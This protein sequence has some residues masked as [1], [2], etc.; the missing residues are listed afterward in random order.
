[1]KYSCRDTLNL[2]RPVVS[3]INYRMHFASCH[4]I[5]IP[6][7]ERKSLENRKDNLH[8]AYMSQSVERALHDA[9]YSVSVKV[10]VKMTFEGDTV[11]SRYGFTRVYK[12]FYSQ[13]LKIR[14]AGEH[15]VV[16][17]PQPVLRQESVKRGIVIARDK[18][19]PS[20]FGILKEEVDLFCCLYAVKAMNISERNEI[21]G[22]STIY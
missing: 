22:E 12:S 5:H 8:G 21:V 17:F 7:F 19:V 9:G 3:S 10:S 11:S 6:K 18:N 15:L 1:M 20:S 4:D 14:Q 2:S 13:S 16:N